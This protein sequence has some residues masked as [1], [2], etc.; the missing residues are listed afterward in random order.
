MEEQM[1][2]IYYLNEK[3]TQIDQLIAI[4]QKKI[5]KLNEYKKSLV[6]EYVTGKRE[7]S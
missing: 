4:K 7:V 3:C 2:I 1:A 5:D 6:Y